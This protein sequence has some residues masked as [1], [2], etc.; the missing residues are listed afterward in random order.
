MTKNETIYE[1]AKSRKHEVAA[2]VMGKHEG[3]DMH[4]GF[5][6]YVRLEKGKSSLI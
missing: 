3:V 2:K 5:S 4:D 1:I 6:A